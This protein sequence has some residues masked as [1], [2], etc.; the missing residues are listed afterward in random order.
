MLNSKHKIYLTA[1]LIIASIF[2]LLPLFNLIKI[3]LSFKP[4]KLIPK[5]SLNY[6][7]EI[8]TYDNKLIN[9]LSSKFDVLDNNQKIPNLL[10]N[11]FI[12]GED[13]RFM[14]HNG[15][16]LIGLFRAF[17][18]NFQSGHIREGGS[19]ITQQV[20]RI[21]FLN[22]DLSLQRKLKEL[23]ISLILDLKYEK[24]HILKLYLNN[25]YLGSGAYGINEAAQ[26]YFGK[27]IDELTLSEIALLAGLAPAPSIYS[28]FN[29]I[30]LSIKNRNRILKIMLKENYIS[31]HEFTKAL[32]E[33]IK[34]NSIQ[35]E[36]SFLNDPVLINFILDET[37]QI[38]NTYKPKKDYKFIKIRSSLNLTW[39]KKAQNLSRL[40]KPKDLEIAL[41]TIESNSGLIRTMISGK[42]PHL[43]TFNRA[44]S[45]IRPLSSTF[46]IISYMAAFEEGKSL[47]DL[48]YDEP[49][50][51]E[52]Y[53]PK[54]F[55]NTYKGKISLLDA[56]KTSSNIIPIK[57]SKELGL[58]KI[59]NLANKLGL[60]YEQRIDKFLSLAIGAYGDSL[61]NISNV[62]STINN[63]GFLIKPS[64]IEKINSNKEEVIWENNFESKR[65]INKI[66]VKK[67]NDIL[68]KSVSE[69]NGIAASIKDKRIFG[70][71]GTSD[72]NRDLWFIGSINGITTG[73]WLG[74]D[75]YKKTNLTSGNASLFWKNYIKSINIL[76]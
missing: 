3:T 48:Y 35:N 2:L 62:Y 60:G 36:S 74:F 47:E 56:F 16:D 28:P 10:K 6:S 15:L 24:N 44:K 14:H 19:T 54:N 33:E 49:T 38:L 57:L 11:A 31:E 43:N 29:N 13:K 64:I 45:A 4:E 63:N 51:W 39:Q 55:S 1:P 25:I 67:L 66:T 71:T 32:N 65:L 7:Y 21:I 34:L 46:K 20:A 37:K 70:K 59:I 23:L 22:N 50:C 17:R 73:V 41:V 68:E 12:S 52:N 76:N 42:E 58:E 9:K 5:D 72:G 26:V 18:N 8:H 27:F 30:N 53:C 40:I 69:G 75:D 61:I